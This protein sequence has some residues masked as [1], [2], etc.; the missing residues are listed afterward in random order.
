MG[1]AKCPHVSHSTDGCWCSNFRQPM[2]FQQPQMTGRTHP[3]T[4]QLQP[5][6]NTAGCRVAVLATLS[7]AS[8]PSCTS[9][10][11]RSCTQQSRAAGSQVC[12]CKQT[13]RV[14]KC[15]KQQKAHLP[16]PVSSHTARNA[17]SQGAAPAGMQQQGTH[18]E[19]HTCAKQPR[20]CGAASAS[21]ANRREEQALKQTSGLGAA[22][23]TF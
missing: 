22:L 2:C 18:T 3:T 11:S 12:G 20:E 1:G 9:I 19:A 14:F 7:P 21:R 6:V 10:T 17:S 16:N 5:C 15:N 4:S 8:S 13:H 23:C